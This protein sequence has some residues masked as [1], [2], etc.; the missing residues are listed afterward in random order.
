VIHE[1]VGGNV[2]SRMKGT[3]LEAYI[4]ADGREI[5]TAHY[6]FFSQR[7]CSACAPSRFG[8]QTAVML[9]QCRHLVY[10]PAHPARLKHAPVKSMEAIDYG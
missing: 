1:H 9:Q 4:V 3:E 7:P 8:Q 6:V 5:K 2:K 10:R